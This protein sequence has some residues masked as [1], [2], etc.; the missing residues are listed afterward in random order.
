VNINKARMLK[1]K[2]INPRIS[3]IRVE[4]DDHI[5][6]VRCNTDDSFKFKP[7]VNLTYDKA[8]NNDSN[9]SDALVFIFH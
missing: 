3:G 5:D 7:E 2:P 9:E 6:C 4:T 1:I 8:S